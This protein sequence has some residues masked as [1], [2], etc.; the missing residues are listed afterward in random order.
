VATI[1]Q[2]TQRGNEDRHQ[3]WARLECADLF[4]QYGALHA[5]GVS[6]RQAAKAWS[7]SRHRP[8][9]ATQWNATRSLSWRVTRANQR[10]W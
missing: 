6:Q 2:E 5:Q 1:N 4:A 10:R 8:P 3:R 7:S 9:E